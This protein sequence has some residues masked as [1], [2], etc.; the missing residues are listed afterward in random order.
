MLLAA[1]Q[2][3]G[4]EVERGEEGGG[5]TGVGRGAEVRLQNLFIHSRDFFT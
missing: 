2:E 1:S 3:R 4:G 5:R